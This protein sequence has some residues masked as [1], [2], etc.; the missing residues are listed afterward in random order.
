MKK[1]LWGLIPL[2]ICGWKIKE[3]DVLQYCRYPSLP[4]EEKMS[5]L[6]N[7][8]VRVGVDLEL[9]G[10]ITYLSAPFSNGNMVN[11]HDWGRQVQMSFYS[12]PVP[13]IPEGR[14]PRPDWRFLG[15]NPIQSGDCEGN[16]S[17]IISHSNNGK[18]IYV[19][20]IPMH[21]PLNN[22]PGSC[23]FESWIRI[24]DN[25]VK[26]RAK[27]TNHRKDTSFYSSRYQEIPAVYTNIKYGQLVTYKG[28]YPF[29]ND[30][31]SYVEKD[32]IPGKGAIEWQYWHAS[33]GWTA[34]LDSKGNGL[35]VWSPETQFFAGGRFG[36]KEDTLGTKAQA[37]TYISPLTAEVLDHNIEFVYDY[38]L[39][40]GSLEEI[41]SFVYKQK[42]KDKERL[43]DYYFFKDRQHIAMY[44]LRDNGWP[45]KEGLDLRKEKDGAYL[46]TSL[47]VWSASAAPCLEIQAAYSGDG[48]KGRVYF[49]PFGQKD[50]DSVQVA[51]FT[52]IPDGKMRKYRIPLYS[53]S[54]YKDKIIQLKIEP[55]PLHSADGITCK[56]KR[57]R[58]LQRKD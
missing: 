17:K 7:G 13:Y 50:F 24:E 9:G 57:I 26:V 14:E 42:K 40:A 41:R 39:I 23:F 51:E 12:G 54:T 49:L 44:G 11:N 48:G 6:D 10:A 36:R 38:V 33:E 3:Q 22:V 34:C 55:F 30:T 31:V 5:F 43:P 19:K 46:L 28:K 29:I 21:W 27:L 18:E 8:I 1:L 52:I 4:G 2:M 20:C 58:L 37:T 15:W 53:S 32:N 25:R 16:R 35:G 47:S 56:I 45:V